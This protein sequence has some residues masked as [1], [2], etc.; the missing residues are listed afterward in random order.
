MFLSFGNDLDIKE[1][2]LNK[3]PSFTLTQ[4]NSKG[5]SYIRFWEIV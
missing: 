1:M 4:Q 2:K 3:F 5:V